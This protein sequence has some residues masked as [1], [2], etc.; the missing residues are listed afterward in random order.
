MR[1]A[2]PLRAPS[3]LSVRRFRADLAGALRRVATDGDYVVLTRRGAPVAAVVPTGALGLLA[4]AD[5]RS[6]GRSPT[7][8]RVPVR[9][10]FRPILAGVLRRVAADG[11]YVLLTRRGVPVAAVVPL[12]V[13]DL[14][15]AADR[16]FAARAVAASQDLHDLE[17]AVPDVAPRTDSAPA[18]PH[19]PRRPAVPP[20]V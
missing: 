8:T 13:L 14:L 1:P 5:A 4:A 7:L 6:S 19:R 20:P 18:S 3:R 10:G 2:L 16:A 9:Y 17:A 12:V 11:G 15:D